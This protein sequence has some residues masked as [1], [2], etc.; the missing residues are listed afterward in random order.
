MRESQ[1][2]KLIRT[3]IGKVEKSANRKEYKCMYPDCNLFS[4][5][6]HSQQKR[7]QLQSISENSRIYALNNSLYSIFGDDINEL[8]VEKTI[9]E[10]SRYKGYCNTHDTNIFI[11]IENGNLNINNPEHNFLLLLRAISFEYAHKRDMHYKLTELF[12]KIRD[13]TSYDILKNFEEHKRGIKLFLDK[14]APVYMNKLYDIYKSRNWSKISYNSFSLNRN[15]G[16]SSTT[17]FSPLREKH[18]EW[19]VNNLYELQPIISLNVVP[20]YNKTSVA[21]VWF[22]EFEKSCDEFIKI[23][24]DQENILQLLN[25]YILCES[26]DTCVKP[27]LWER[28]NQSERYEIYRHMSSSHSLSGA[29]SVPLLLN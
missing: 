17:C 16:V 1:R 4:I 10:V 18:C 9:G 8:L 24:K 20:E 14:D 11:P 15:L 7:H 26:E 25:T 13:F 5:K 27:S 3:A 19:A 6:S 22:S 2:I 29:D 12:N 28:L 23:N 21:F